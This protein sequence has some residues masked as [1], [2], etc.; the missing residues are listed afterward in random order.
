MDVRSD[1]S[2]ASGILELLML[3]MDITFAKLLENL[4]IG[5]EK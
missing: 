3:D 1:V 4:G 2:Y 5:K